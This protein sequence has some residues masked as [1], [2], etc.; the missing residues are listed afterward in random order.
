MAL[1]DLYQQVR[2][3][4][5]TDASGRCCIC[6]L[7]RLL[8]ILQVLHLTRA[9]SEVL[10]TTS[11][12]LRIQLATLLLNGHNF[13]MQAEFEDICE[14]AQL[15]TRLQDL[16]QLCQEQGLNEGEAQAAG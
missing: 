9:N 14:E 5:C 6:N 12:C 3:D 2:L 11:L 10:D 8:C 16:E 1:Y 15:W 13:V 4:R 7:T